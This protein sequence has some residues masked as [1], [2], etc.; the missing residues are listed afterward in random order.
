[1]NLW[2]LQ[3]HLERTPKHEL[4]QN[5]RAKN[6]AVI[7]LDCFEEYE[8]EYTKDETNYPYA[9]EWSMVN[10]LKRIRDIE[11][12]KFRKPCKSRSMA[13]SKK[14]IENIIHWKC[15]SD[16]RRA[17]ECFKK[18]IQASH[19][20]NH[21]V[22]AVNSVG[23]ER[24]RKESELTRIRRVYR[25]TLLVGENMSIISGLEKRKRPNHSPDSGPDSDDDESRLHS[26]SRKTRKIKLTGI[27]PAKKT[28]NRKRELNSRIRKGS[29]HTRLRNKNKD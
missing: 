3:N 19:H 25:S 7:T 22:Y 2:I 13:Y 20:I 28:T 17:N 29:S 18:V 5:I 21:A 15:F 4:L 9:Q 24:K 8:N 16:E 27:K 6:Y 26:S 1:L 10:L 12:D 14:F 11:D 23:L